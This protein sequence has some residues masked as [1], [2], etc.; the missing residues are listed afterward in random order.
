[1]RT[2]TIETAQPQRT[3]PDG[4]IPPIEFCQVAA[5]YRF[6]NLDL[7]QG[8]LTHASGANTRLSSNE[9]M[10]FL[11]DSILG[12]VVCEELFRRFP[13]YQEGDLTKMKSVLVSRRTCARFAQEL[14]LERCLITGKGING[15]G[16]SLPSNM[17]ADVYESLVAAIYLDGGMA[18]AKEFI[19]R[20]LGPEIETVLESGEF[21][22]SKSLLQQIGQ[23]DFGQAPL[24]VLLDEKGPDH[25]KCFKIAAVIGSQTYPGAWGR[26]KKEAEQR[27]ASNALAELQVHAP[28]RGRGPGH[29][30]PA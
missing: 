25:S 20:Q 14:G 22:N 5:N 8:A 24:Y 27:A 11:G 21:G 29:S 6:N 10:E 18:A 30:D 9:R 2:G 19:L 26:N 28:I 4:A 7:L 16:N 12:F 23:R 1:M 17:L 15:R 3:A 13:E